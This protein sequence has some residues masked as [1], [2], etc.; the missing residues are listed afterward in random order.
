MSLSVFEWLRRKLF[1]PLR[2]SILIKDQPVDGKNGK[3]T[4]EKVIKALPAEAWTLLA[5]GRYG[6]AVKIARSILDDDPEHSAALYLLG[7][8]SLKVHGFDTAAGLFAK[9]AAAGGGEPRNHLG[10]GE[11]L[12]ALKK[13]DQAALSLRLAGRLAPDCDG[14]AAA[15]RDLERRC[16]EVL[17]CDGQDMAAN[18]ALGQVLKAMGRGDEGLVHHRRALK[19]NPGYALTDPHDGPKLLA[20]GKI[21]E[22]WAEFEWRSTIGSIGP[23]TEMVWKGEDLAGRTILVWGEQGIG[24]QILFAD[25]IADVIAGAGKV[26]I[27]VDERL[28]PLFARSFRDAVVH[29]EARFQ[30]GEP[31]S[32]TAIGWLDE[33][34]PVDFFIPQGS[35]PRFFRRTLASF[36]GRRSIL[37]ASPQGVAFWRR[38]LEGLG[39]GRKVGVAWRSVLMTE[40]RAAFYPPLDA[41]APLFALPGTEFVAVQANLEEAERSE[42]E[43]RFAITLHA[44]D[45]I[46]LADDLDGSAALLSSLDAVV[47][48]DTYLPMLA[49]AVG[50]ATWRVTRSLKKKD[51]SFLGAERYP[52]F[53]AMTVHFGE[54]NDE[55]TAIFER[56]ARQLRGHHT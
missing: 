11:A 45:D 9:A 44:F 3:S 55:L 25:C 6:D 20:A 29:G 35:L 23:F 19:Y 53:P 28:V 8:V 49:A 54:T 51:W 1:R 10:L 30:G 37:T 43:R 32:W 48:A 21:E 15:W 36:P 41:W 34:G 33:H 31:V 50:T 38:R 47:S 46:D 40:K 13:Y 27:E 12:V 39:P 7:R 22:G 18:F 24:E 52:W 26:I 4:T 56:I 2:I 16:R 42:I 14:L 5:A 17:V